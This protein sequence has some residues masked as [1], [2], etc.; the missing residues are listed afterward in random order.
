[1]RDEEKSLIHS[2]RGLAYLKDGLIDK[3]IE[4]FEISLNYAPDNIGAI[5]NLGTAL[6]QKGL[7][8]DAISIL[9][10]LLN[11]NWEISD[12]NLGIIHYNLGNTYRDKK[13]EDKAIEQYKIAIEKRPN[14]ASTWY[15]LGQSYF[16]KG[17]F[18]NAIKAYEKAIENNP[19]HTEAKDRLAHLKDL[20]ASEDIEWAKEITTKPL[21]EY[22]K[23]SVQ[24]EKYRLQGK[25]NS[26][27]N[28]FEKALDTYPE[29]GALY[30]RLAGAQFDLM[31]EEDRKD[32][33]VIQEILKLLNKAEQLIPSGKSKHPMDKYNGLS[34][35]HDLKGRCYALLENYQLATEELEKALQI[36]PDR[37]DSL[38]MLSK[39]KSFKEFM[40]KKES[41]SKGCFMA[42]AVYSSQYAPEVQIL[43]KFRDNYLSKFPVIG[44]WLI[45]NYYKISPNIAKVMKQ[46]V[47]LKKTCRII[48]I[49]PIVKLIVQFCKRGIK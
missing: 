49:N 31:H 6:Q 29:E 30:I 14:H 7:F 38:R 17:E 32:P 36:D 41:K 10:S 13:L 8:N 15:N 21:D 35:L 11:Q 26:A 19:D 5:V 45:E 39:I 9:K 20:K 3:A 25:L 43:K 28:E 37:E 42:T 22:E 27:I 2:K 44:I 46:S 12:E 23:M 40:Q 24:G 33:S 34:E 1:M 18:E 47:F 48:V 4:E 16:A